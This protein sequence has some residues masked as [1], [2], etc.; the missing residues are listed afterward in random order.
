MEF[1]KW[2]DFSKSNKFKLLV[3]L[4]SARSKT[5]CPGEEGKTKLLWNELEQELTNIEIEVLN[6]EVD[7]NP[8][9]MPCKGCVSTAG[10][11]HCHYPCDCYEPDQGDFMSDFDVYKKG[12]WA[13]G[14]LLITPIYWFSVPGQVKNLFDRLVCINQ[15]ITTEEAIDLLGDNI[16]SAE[17]TRA[18][19]D[20]NL[21]NH[22]KGKR[23]AFIVHGDDGANDYKTGL[24]K[25][26]N[27]DNLWT[28]VINLPQIAI[29]P[30]VEQMRYSEVEVRD[31]WILTKHINRGKSYTDANLEVRT[32]STEWTDYINLSIEMVKNFI[33]E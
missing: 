4:G 27:P 9:V 31:E 14:I 23:A 6:L 30:I 5:S 11:A 19:K 7:E 28:R 17:H 33:N 2:N 25:T 21:Q 3:I 16:K 29:M 20:L 15:T 22:W 26:Y 10:G 24:P 12:E 8:I 32:G 18:L 13:D 1:K